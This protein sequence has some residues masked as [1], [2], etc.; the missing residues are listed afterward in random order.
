MFILQMGEMPATSVNWYG[1]YGRHSSMNTWEEK[2]PAF[3][4]VQSGLRNF[5]CV[6]WFTFVN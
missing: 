3:A 2:M 5:C 1:W 4:H 6:G